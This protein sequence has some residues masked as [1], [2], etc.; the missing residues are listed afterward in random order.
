MQ[1][2]G[3]TIKTPTDLKVGV[4]RITKAERLASGNMAMEIIAVKRRL[5]LKWAIIADTDLQK[6]FNI[7]ESRVFHSVTYLDPQGG[8]TATI[9]AY[10]GDISQEAWQR[11]K[12]IRYWRDVSIALIEQ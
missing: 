3:T 5:D 7:L 1:I 6:I 9:T 2:N 4:F 10:V 8:E 12:G 11:L